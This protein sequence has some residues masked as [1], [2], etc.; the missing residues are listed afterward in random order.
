MIQF[1]QI[2]DIAK[3]V[4]TPFYLAYPDQF[5]ANIEGFHEAFSSL[6]PHFILSYSFKTNYTPFLL[7]AIKDHG[8]YAEV[9]SEIEYDLATLL[10]FRG[11]NIVLNG[12]IKG[13]ALLTKAINNQSI[14]NLDCLYEVDSVLKIKEQNPSK[15]ISIGL[16][17]NMEINTNNGASAIQG[18]LKESR[19]GFTEAMLEEVIPSLKKSGIK[20]VSLHGHTSSTNRV[21]DNYKIIANRLLDVCEKFQLDDVKFLDLGGGFFGAAPKEVDT[22]KR[23][24]Y[25]DYAKGIIET[26]TQRP[27]FNSHQ[28]YILIEPGASVVTNVFEVVTKIHQQKKI[29]GKDFVIV[30]A[31]IYQVR[32]PSG[33]ANYPY[34]ECSDKPVQDPI[35]ADIVGST[36]MEIDVVAN[37]V[38]LTHYR[39]GDYLVFKASGAYRQN[40][41]PFFINPRCAIV[42][43]TSD[44]FKVIRKRQDA[45]H[46]LEMLQ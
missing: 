14:V 21:V 24:S 2:T 44:G 8:F 42:E 46:L 16:R 12:P 30:D 3:E 38:K 4:G 41:T 29:H 26:M 17:V 35:T 36:C 19:F 45:K 6:Y 32:P 1:S 39:N 15:Q 18:G 37:Q 43:L 25:K 28:P 31:S 5:N 40:L 33:K 13:E 22:S 20:I 34:D 23:P 7:K 9:V 11:D 10:G 27:W